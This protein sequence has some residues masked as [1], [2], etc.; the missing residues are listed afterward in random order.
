MAAIE[1]GRQNGESIGDSIGDSIS[2][3]VAVR[4]RAAGIDTDLL[5]EGSQFN[6]NGEVSYSD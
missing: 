6:F 4:R 5:M 1:Y 2:A 3:S